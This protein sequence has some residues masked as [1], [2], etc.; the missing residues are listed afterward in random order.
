VNK[1]SI[2]DVSIVIPFLDEAESLP[3]LYEQIMEVVLKSAWSYEIIFVDDGSHDD[4]WDFV[5]SISK[6]NPFI[7]GIKFTR[8]YGKS[9]ALHVGFELAQGEVV[10]TM[11][12]DLQDNPHELPVLY[13]KLINENLD[14]V[15]GWKKIRHDPLFGK[16]IP[17]KFFNWTARRFSGIPLNDFNCGL[18]AYKREVVKAIH[19]HGEMHRYIPLLAKHAGYSAIG[20][21][22]VVHSRRK[23]GETKFGLDRFVKGFLD[24]ISL[25]FV[26]RFGKRPM[27]FFGLIGSLM[28]LTGFCFAIYLGIDKLYLE[29]EGRL[30]TER[31]EF[32][33]SLTTMIL[34]SQFFLAGFLAELI[35]RSKQKAPNYTVREKI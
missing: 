2:T 10:F 16:T 6:T 29:T 26:Q 12:A 35:M 21:Q 9:Q 1:L 14:I 30:I 7:K 32:Y 28:L 17:S 33:I 27:H 22:V 4:G 34:G 13:N 19:V 25:V 15:S 3:E 5:R 31:P 18:K 11:D 23:Y 20:E 8:N 24:L